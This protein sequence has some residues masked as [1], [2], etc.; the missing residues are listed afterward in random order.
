MAIKNTAAKKPKRPAGATGKPKKP[1]KPTGQQRRSG[2]T[3]KANGHDHSFRLDA[4]GNGDTSRDG[5]HVHQVIRFKVQS[6]QKHIH[7]LE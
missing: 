1:R 7:R 4:Q 3:T 5:G 6:A 2:R